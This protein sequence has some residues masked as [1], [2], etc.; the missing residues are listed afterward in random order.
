M[1]R[2]SAPSFEQRFAEFF[3][4]KVFYLERSNCF[5]SNFVA[6]VLLF[7]QVFTKVMDNEFIAFL[8]DI[9]VGISATLILEYI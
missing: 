4:S 9:Y 3:A 5:F 6:A 1:E 8:I 7:E 2:R